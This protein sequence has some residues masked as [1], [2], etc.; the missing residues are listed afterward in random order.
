MTSTAASSSELIDI[1][2]RIERGVALYPGD[3]PVDSQPLCEIGP[4]APCNITSLVNWT[5]HFLTHV[6]PPRHFFPDGATLDELP[7]DRWVGRARVV[8]VDG[9]A[10]EAS[11]IPSDVKGLNVLFK[12][13][14]SS[15]DPTSFDESHVYVTANAAQA[16]VAGRAN[17]VG[18][19]Y[20]SIDKFGD[21]D[22]PAHKTLLGGNVLVLEGLDLSASTPGE[23]YLSAL[24]LKIGAA[25]GSP[26][27]AVLERR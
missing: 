26:V 12:T 11:D 15:A 22:Y 20:H 6:D 8:V 19:D 25:D 4:E 23:Y 7:L 5:T 13:R 16:L 1:S 24:P 10:I 2:R 9:P 21:E 18:F 27:R 17:L 3:D 14:N